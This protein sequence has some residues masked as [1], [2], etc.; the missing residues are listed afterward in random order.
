MRHIAAMGKYTAYMQ[1][2]HSIHTLFNMA[3]LRAPFDQVKYGYNVDSDNDHY[4]YNHFAAHN[5]LTG[6]HRN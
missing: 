5:D 4:K 2:C 1:L 3:C 6:V